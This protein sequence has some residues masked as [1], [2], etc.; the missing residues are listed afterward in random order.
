[1]HGVWVL[2]SWSCAEKRKLESRKQKWEIGGLA[3]VSMVQFGPETLDLLGFCETGRLNKVQF[4]AVLVPEGKS[5]NVESRKQ[6]WKTGG[7]AGPVGT[8]Q[9]RLASADL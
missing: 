6:K 3:F 1:M 5:R 8:W 4:G 7:R 9:G 2:E